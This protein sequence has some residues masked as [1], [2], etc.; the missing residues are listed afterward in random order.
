MESCPSVAQIYRI[1]Q[2]LHNIWG[3]DPR[4]RSLVVWVGTWSVLKNSLLGVH[5]WILPWVWFLLIH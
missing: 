5:S 2:V 1:V 4:E 3:K